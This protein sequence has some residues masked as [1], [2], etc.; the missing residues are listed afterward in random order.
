MSGINSSSRGVK[1]KPVKLGLL[2]LGT[3][4]AGLVAV[5][6]RNAALIEARAGRPLQVVSAAIRDPAKARG[7]QLD[8]IRLT[9]DPWQVVNDPE[10]EV[11]V[12]LMGGLE[13]ARELVLR[14][15]ELN[16]PVVTA[17]KA[18]IARCGNELLAKAEAAQV[19]IGFE[20]SVAGGIPV[21]GALREGLASSQIQSLAGIINGTCNFILTEMFS[22]GCGFAEVLAQAQALGYAEADPTFDIEGIDAAHKLCILASLAFATPLDMDAVYCEGI[23]RL[24]AEDI[25]Y[26]RDLGYRIKSL[27][28]ARRDEQGLELRVHPALVAESQ[29]LAKVDGV[30]N[31]VQIEGDAVGP[32][33]FYGR[34]AGAEPT[35]SAVLADLIALARGRLAPALSVPVAQLQALPIKHISQ[36]SSEAYLRLHVADKPGVLSAITTI[37][38]QHGISIDALVQK[39]IKAGQTDVP[40]VVLTHKVAE[41][42]L[43]AA[44]AAIEA[45]EVVTQPVLRLRVA[46]LA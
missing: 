43:N 14:A 40:L 39:E 1:V 28:I 37:L 35:A 2:G 5:L 31:A 25:Q 22:K 6:Q 44:I 21:L 42:Q 45:L 24:T 7:C 23:S 32:T 26:V 12:E 19:A 27:G 11:I 38:A 30:F 4:G 36:I 13:P 16:K 20:A 3:V 34:G 18:L 33:L 17:N 29:L 10:V 15:I 41:A 46:E 9:Q 8:G